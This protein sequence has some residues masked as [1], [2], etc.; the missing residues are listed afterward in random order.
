MAETSTDLASAAKNL[1]AL[2]RNA[3]KTTSATAEDHINSAKRFVSGMAR[4]L[5]QQMGLSGT[6]TKNPVVV[7]DLAC[8]SGV[9]TQELQKELPVEILEKSK[10]VSGDSSEALV[11]VVGK[12]VEAE[13]WRNVEPRVTDAMVRRLSHIHL[14]RRDGA[15]VYLQDTKLPDDTF[16]HV[17]V[18]MG[19]HLI[20]RP[21]DALRGEST[22]R[23]WGLDSNRQISSTELRHIRRYLTHHQA[24]RCSGGNNATL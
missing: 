10:F 22:G 15:N 9:V 17:A 5:I 12:R 1:S 6:A 24:G 4:P 23:N 20:P 16:S 19:L 14:D 3:G 21:D 2:Y 7:L 11:G 18:A 8:G 13:G